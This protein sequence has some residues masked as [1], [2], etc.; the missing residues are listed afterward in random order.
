MSQFK[1]CGTCM[2]A[3]EGE[4]PEPDAYTAQRVAFILA[5]PFLL[6]APEFDLG[7]LDVPCECCAAPPGFRYLVEQL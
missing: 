6:L 3:I 1:V 2:T 7:E 5:T 4:E